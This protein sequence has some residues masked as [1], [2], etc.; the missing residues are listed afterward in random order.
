MFILFF[1]FY[2]VDAFHKHRRIVYEH[3]VLILWQ[4]TSD[5]FRNTIL[6]VLKSILTG[7]LT[8]TIDFI[9]KWFI[10]LDWRF[11]QSKKIYIWVCILIV[12]HRYIWPSVFSGGKK[13][14]WFDSSLEWQKRIIFYYNES[15]LMLTWYLICFD[16]LKSDQS[17]THAH[18]FW[19]QRNSIKL[20]NWWIAKITMIDFFGTE[21]R[22][23]VGNSQS[24]Q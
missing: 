22:T 9:D 20:R 4:S 11:G 18:K 24:G 3:F 14:L 10:S 19:L 15:L 17:L 16:V 12:N 21:F 5:T 2:R 23:I 6:F 8:K 7:K 13:Q 1:V